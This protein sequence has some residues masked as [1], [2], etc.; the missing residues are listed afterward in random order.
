MCK[1][2][3][4]RPPF[5]SVTGCLGAGGKHVNVVLPKDGLIDLE[6]WDSSVH[7]DADLETLLAMLVRSGQVCVKDDSNQG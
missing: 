3:A 1:L 7:G 4:P 6:F 2:N 5:A